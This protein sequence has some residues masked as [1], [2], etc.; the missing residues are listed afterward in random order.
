MMKDLQAKLALG[1]WLIC[2]ARKIAREVADDACS[3]GATQASVQAR[4]V[5]AAL[6]MALAEGRAI[7]GAG[8]MIRPNFGGGK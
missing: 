2:Q 3:E 8:G 4:K 7:E 1:E 6:T 5:E